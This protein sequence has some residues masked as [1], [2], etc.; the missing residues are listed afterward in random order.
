MIGNVFLLDAPD[1]ERSGGVARLGDYVE[2]LAQYGDWLRVRVK[3][4]EQAD[5]E[6]AGWVQA[7]WVRLLRPVPVAYITPTVRP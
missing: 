5:V 2:I 7:R 3:S 1:G 4:A 6:V